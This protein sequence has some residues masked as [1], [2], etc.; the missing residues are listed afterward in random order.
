VSYEQEISDLNREL[1][2]RVAELE[3]LFQ[4]MPVGIAIA[5]DAECRRIRANTALSRMLGVPATANVSRS[6]PDAE[7]PPLRYFREGRELQAED[8]PQQVVGRTGRE[9]RAEELEFERPDG[10]RGMMFGNAAPLFDEQGHTRGSVAAW[11]DISE[12]RRMEEQLR[13]SEQTL[14]LAFR[15][16]GMWSW[17]IDL[18]N[19]VITWSEEARTQR[20][21]GQQELRVPYEQWL[22]RV[23]PVD[24]EQVSRKFLAAVRGEAEYDLEYRTAGNGGEVV[25]IYTRGT[26]VRDSGGKPVRMIG[27][28]MDV[29]ER[30]RAEEALRASEKLAATGKLAAA[31]AHEINNPLA[32]VTILVY[33]MDHDPGLNS[34]SR[35]YLSMAATELDR[36]AHITRSMLSFYRHPAAPSPMIISRTVEGVVNLHRP[37]LQAA[38]VQLDFHVQGEYPAVGYAPEIQQ[39]ISNL[40]LNAME[41]MPGGGKVLVEVRA[42]RCWSGDGLT[43]TRIMIADDG[44]GIP[45]EHR[46]RLFEPFYSTKGGKGT[47]LGLWVCSNLAERNRGRLRFR[48]ATGSDRHGTCFCLFLPDA[49]QRRQPS[50]ALVQAA[51]KD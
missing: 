34:V 27:V 35:N 8:L 48:T 4:V 18:N 17:E 7:R 40:L 12:R 26:L 30:K 11:I 49:T 45:L 38:S 37:Q 28:G 42:S 36:V 46:H 44:P 31:L 41:S 29:T 23:D 10:S 5:E 24:R 2:R 14:R 3:T 20:G 43:G 39:V 21:P 32:A 1:Q 50:S 6:A 25:W 16:A 13:Q 9:V 19:M 15:A 33:L 47:G 22:A 51:G